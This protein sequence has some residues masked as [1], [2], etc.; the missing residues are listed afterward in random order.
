MFG[1]TFYHGLIRKYVAL[2]GTLFNEIYINRPNTDS[3]IINTI[4]VPIS[5]G[6]S[7]KTLARL[8]S[9]PS[10]N[11]M[12]AIILPRMAF[13]I[14]TIS[15]AG[16]RK[17]PTVNRA[18]VSQLS[19]DPDKLSYIYNPVPYDIDFSLYIMVKNTDDGTRII[20]QIL[21]FF[22]PEWTV[23]A[24]LITDP[25]II[26]DIPVILTSV[27]MKDE[28]EASFEERRVLMWTLKFTLKGYLFGPKRKSNI[29]K[30]SNT[31]LHTSLTS[32]SAAVTI[33]IVPGLDANGNPTTNA[34]DSI[35]YTLIDVNDNF[36]YIVTKTDNQYEE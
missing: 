29:I 2:F 7:D 13:E 17:L 35:N 32:N 28:Y 31:N 14:D 23:T 1:H 4:K 18:K 3:N 33:N 30:F 9:D 34:N 20:E 22:T 12:P 36:G 26:M 27:E 24:Q 10:L 25:S 16:E 15:Y 5:Y 21:P 6:P 8:D 11:R 19:S